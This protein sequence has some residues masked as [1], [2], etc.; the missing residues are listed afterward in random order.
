MKFFF[1][2][3]LCWVLFIQSINFKPDRVSV[4]YSDCDSI[5]ELNKQIITYVKT[6]IGKKV[7]KG[8]CWDLAAQALN[9]VDAKWDKKYVFGEEINAKKECVF[10]GDIIQFEGVKISYEENGTYY[11]ENIAHHTAIIFEVKDKGSFILAQQNTSAH[12][13]KVS[14]DPLELKHITKGKFKIYRPIR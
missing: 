7:D 12:G 1:A 11:K 6:T 9:S 4:S 14:L 10:P 8:E 13:R 3:V 5:P 2:S